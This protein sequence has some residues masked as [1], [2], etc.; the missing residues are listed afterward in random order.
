M[1]QSNLPRFVRQTFPDQLTILRI[2]Y[3]QKKIFKHQRSQITAMS[4][5]TKRTT[6]R[7]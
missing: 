4:D 6:H 3:S 2:I 1:S 7:I 5:T